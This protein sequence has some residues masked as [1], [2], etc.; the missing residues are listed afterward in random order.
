MTRIDPHGLH[1]PLAQHGDKRNSR[2]TAD[3]LD[4]MADRQPVQGGGHREDLR[5][6]HMESAGASSP[7]SDRQPAGSCGALRSQGDPQSRTADACAREWQVMHGASV[8]DAGEGQARVFEQHWLANG[9]LSFIAGAGEPLAPDKSTCTALL[10]EGQH[11]AASAATCEPTGVASANAGAQDFVPRSIALEGSGN[12]GP[13]RRSI[14]GLARALG[15]MA[16]LGQAWPERLLRLTHKAN[17]RVTI[18]VRDYSLPSQAIGPLV[19]QLRQM[20]REQGAA[21][22]CVMVNGAAAWRADFKGE[23]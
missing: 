4:H 7:D 3:F 19:A 12:A 6:R 5:D 8:P 1:P 23:A 20:A 9:Y 15:P 16:I 22:E 18:W 2:Q 21:L 13:V 11:P 17:G 10:P 14:E